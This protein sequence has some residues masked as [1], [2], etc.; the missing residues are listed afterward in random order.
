MG[1]YVHSDEFDI[2]KFANSLVQAGREAV[3]WERRKLDWI[4]EE[5]KAEQK[6]TSK[7]A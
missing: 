2:E 7:D 3:K 1:S 4:L 5:K 6:S